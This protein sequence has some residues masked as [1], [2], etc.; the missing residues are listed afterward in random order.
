MPARE[1]GLL[2]REEKE[3]CF[4]FHLKVDSESP[5]QKGV[6]GANRLNCTRESLIYVLSPS[7]MSDSCNPADC[8]PSGSC[9]HGLSS[10]NT[11][12]GCHFL[13]QGIFLT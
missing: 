13:L 1:L 11:E 6:L 12:V 4:A 5:P 8:S 2:R 3:R 10:K 7:I 9:V